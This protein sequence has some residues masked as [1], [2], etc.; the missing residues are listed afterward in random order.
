MR[1][2]LETDDGS[3]TSQK[4][5]E[6]TGNGAVNITKVISSEKI[7]QTRFNCIVEAHESTRPSMESITK[8]NHEDHI[9]GKG[10][11]SV[12]YYIVV[13]KFIPMPQAMTISDAKEAVDKEWKKLETIP[14]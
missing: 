8:E 13:H 9:A 6:L 4:T 7:P 10:Q 5:H 12:F 3:Y 1:E 2:N 11:I 14:A